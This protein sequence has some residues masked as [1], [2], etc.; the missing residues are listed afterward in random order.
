MHADRGR[1]AWLIAGAC[2]MACG[3]DD[4]SRIPEPRG[5]AL[6]AVTTQVLA[7]PSSFTSYIALVGSLTN[8]G[9][10]AL[11]DALELP[12]RAQAVGPERDGV[13]F[14]LDG[15][16]PQITRYEVTPAGTLSPGAVLSFAAHGVSLA[17]ATMQQF[18]FAVDSSAYLLDTS[19][20][21]LFVWDTAS[22][23]IT[24]KVALEGLERAGLSVTFG[25][26]PFLRDDTLFFVAAYYSDE[27]QVY[28]RE[29]RLVAVNVRAP[30]AP[31]V[32][33][34]RRCAFLAHAVRLGNGDAY[35]GSDVL[36]AAAARRLGSTH[37]GPACALR[38]PA[39]A[40]RWDDTV[41]DFAARVGS[42]TAGSLVASGDTHALVRVLDESLVPDLDAL[43]VAELRAGPYW[44]WASL[45]LTTDEPATPLELDPSAAGVLQYPV[46]GKTYTIRSSAG[47]SETTVVDIAPDGRVQLGP[48]IAGTVVSIV[49]VR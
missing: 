47:F 22:M 1:G 25:T 11:A 5:G 15:E 17:P 44:R 43:T 13:L 4:G 3:D 45:D 6:Y 34:D 12:G 28:D 41:I 32:V 14:V 7:P 23:T 19:T 8:D 27:E 9:E 21:Q 38:L 42:T 20:L 35:F 2:S 48:T 16:S 36:T 18:V 30:S 31:S 37:G 24:G 10:V 39:A 33:P 49:R 40:E 46:D 29:S 26:T